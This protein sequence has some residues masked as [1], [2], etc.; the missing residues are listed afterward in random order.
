MYQG[1]LKVDGK[2][3]EVVPYEDP[4]DFRYLCDLCAT[5]ICDIH[6]SC[7]VCVN[8]EFRMC[9][10]CCQVESNCIDLPAG[11][12]VR[13]AGAVQ[14]MH[15]LVQSSHTGRALAV[16]R[17]QYKRTYHHAANVAA[18]SMPVLLLIGLAGSNRAAIIVFTT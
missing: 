18:S 16:S 8:G 13:S 10:H 6:H 11:C 14:N 4:K 3:F 1:V 5:S 9:V 15:V 12:Q 2:L 7:P 17:L